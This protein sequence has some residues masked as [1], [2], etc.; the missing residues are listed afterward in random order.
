M[1]GTGH[2]FNPEIGQAGDQVVGIPRGPGRPGLPAS[3][4]TDTKAV[5]LLPPDD[6]VLRPAGDHGYHRCLHAGTR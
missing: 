5:P 4:D 1:G 6:P 2:Q 3:D